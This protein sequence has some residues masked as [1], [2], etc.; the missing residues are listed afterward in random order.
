MVNFLNDGSLIGLWPLN[1][2]SGAAIFL[3]YSPARSRCPSGISFDFHVA[4]AENSNGTQAKSL[5][6]GTTS[7]F[8]PGSGTVYNGYMVQGYW[9]LGANSAPFSKYLVM[10]NGCSQTR[11]QTLAPN[12]EQS[13]ITVGIWIYPNSNGYLNYLADANTAS[14]NGQTEGLRCHALYAQKQFASVGGWQI[15][16][17]G[18]LQQAAQNGSVQNNQQLVAY[19]S[20]ERTTGSP[21]VINTPIESGRYTHIAFS[22]RYING[23]ADEVVLYKDGRVAASGTS[24]TGAGGSSSTSLGNSTLVTRALTIGGGDNANT[25][26]NN[27]GGTTGWNHLVSGAYLF[28]RVLHEGEVLDLHSGSTLQPL[29]DNIDKPIKVE[30]TDPQLL[31][32][33]PFRSVGWPDVT[34]NHRPLIS[35]TDEGPTLGYIPVP[36]PFKG[37]GML[38]NGT[39]SFEHF[40]ATSGLIYEMLSGRSWSI[41]IF[42]GPVNSNNRSNN[43][44]VSMGSVS[45]A[46]TTDPTA[47]SQ[48]TFGFVLTQNTNAPVTTRFEAYPLGDLT[49]DIYRI[50]TTS[51]GLYNGVVHHHGIAYD[52]STKG[53]AVYLDG[54]LQGS[55][56]LKHSLTDQLIRVAG[57]GYPLM[58][59]N[60]V[61]NTIS[62]QASHG[63]LAAG[64]QDTFLGPIT[65][66]GRAL[67][68]QEFMYLAQ[69][70]IDTTPLWRTIHDTRLVG[71]WPCSD[72]K[73]DDIIVEDR[74]RVWNIFPGNLTR[75]ETD[76][77]WNIYASNPLI[78]EFATRDTIGALASYGNLGITSGIFGVHGLSP[79]TAVVS[80]AT[81]ARSSIGNLCQRYKPVNEECDTTPQN[82][83]GDFV[84]S[85]EVT[86]SGR[87]PNTPFGLTANATKFE[88]NSTLSLYG[89]MGA[90]TTDGELRS[91][92]TTV[93]EAQGSGVSLVFASRVG[94]YGANTN[95]VSLV[96]G[97]VPFGVPSKI[98][99]HTKFDSPYDNSDTLGSTPLTVTLWINGVVVQRRRMTSA[100]ARV[101]APG[102]TDSTSDNYL[103]QF[104]GEAGNDTFTTQIARDGGLG[105]IYMR[106]MFLMRGTFDTGE[107]Q[108]LAVSGIQVPTITGYTPTLTKTQV[109]IGDNNLEGYW[110]FNGDVQYSGI[111]DLSLKGNDLDPLGQKNNINGVSSAA[112]R[113]LKFLSG[114]LANSDLGVQ[115]SGITYAGQSNGSTNLVPPFAVSGVAFD[116]PQNGFSVGF[117][118][119]KRNSPAINTQ[120]TMLCYGTVGAN[121]VANS[122]VDFNKGWTIYADETNNIK[123]LVSVGGT[124]YFKNLSNAAQSGQIVCGSFDG[125]S[126]YSDL[127]RFNNYE[128][129]NSKPPRIDF[130]S[131]YCW[132]YDSSSK[133]LICYVNGQEVDRKR[134]QYDVDPLNGGPPSGLNPLIPVNPAARMITFFSPQMSA[135]WDFSAS[136]LNDENTI[137]T[138]V[139]YFSRTLS[140]PEVRYI[141]QNGIDDSQRIT[142]SG[143]IGGYVVGSDVGS[144]LIGGYQRGQDSVSGIIGAMSFGAFDASGI[145]GG[146][147]SGVMFESTVSGVVGGYIHGY[148]F[149][150]GIIGGYIRGTGS[151]SG[152][153]GGF[154]LGG[155]RGSMQFDGGFTVQAIAAQDFDSQLVIRQATNADFDA[156]IVIFQ[157]E[158]GPLVDIIT[159]NATVSG[160]TA[161]F[162]QYFVGAASGTQ[163]KSIVQA[164]WTFGDLTPAVTVLESG[165]GFYPNQH[166][167]ASSGFFIAKF[168]AIDSNGLHGSATRIINATSGISPVIISVSGVPRS[169]NAALIVDFT[170]TVDNLPPGVAINASLLNFDDGQSTITFNPTHVYSEPGTYKPIW[171]VRDSRGVI[172]CDSLEAGNDFLKEI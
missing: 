22:Y 4:Q 84:L 43:M 149:G 82:A 48:A 13:G 100:S 61:A 28:R 121:G 157:V 98:L 80:N 30:L 122:I 16:V 71:Y 116:S 63:T 9:K 79:G 69:S 57:S 140:E 145:I 156:K 87:I 101:W 72:Y 109:V 23:T 110:R 75:G 128:F 136:N 32:H 143:L 130:W 94:T 112:T 114:P 81:S 31:A 115:C 168:E 166:Y 1:E 126:I 37:G 64:G 2:P 83:I 36:G 29:Q 125:A 54:V 58:F 91:F 41:G 169:G 142:V 119:S 164:R 78:S 50:D 53:I 8:N 44:I 34:K 25:G 162:N 148:D 133:E 165:A 95:Y 104:G 105:D 147:V 167:Y 134:T 90:G 18:N 163:G 151:V 124:S 170:T 15:G 129:G 117:L 47:I 46:T 111:R 155:L 107:I 127:T 138:D 97:V 132:A 20:I 154:V 35:V 113:T 65:I 161:P 135:P 152:I 39:N 171:C 33:Y 108:A 5:W 6:P 102:G 17:S 24:N 62:N 77:R 88:A 141:S 66:V 12:I 92:L 59:A 74:A 146:Y 89:N 144:G 153:F 70:G 103:L 86:P 56:I 76:V 49:G 85:Y 45:A 150:S 26:T 10:G 27:Y 131:H 42:A 118:M 123:M 52:D 73:I 93:D 3:N 21:T 67:L 19:A 160:V 7:V 55:G 172:W 139:F 96:S 40:V 137:L 68:P 14:Y 106:E 60:G 11:A 99:F 158:T 159:P 38:H 120:E 51:S